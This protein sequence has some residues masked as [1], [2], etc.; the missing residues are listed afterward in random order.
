ME[1][2]VGLF[3]EEE[4]VLLLNEHKFKDLSNNAKYIIT[5]MFGHVNDEEMIHAQKIEGSFKP[6]FFVEVNGIRKNVSMKSG[7]NI[8]IHQELVKQF[9][10][11][12]KMKGISKETTD[13]I[14]L[15]HYGDMTTDGTGKERFPYRKI[16]Y[17][18][19]KRIKKANVELNANKEFVLVMIYR[20]VFIG[21][22]RDNIVAD[23][24]YH[25]DKEFGVVVSRKQVFKH[26]YNGKWDF[27]EN[28][29]IGPIILHP[30]ARYVGREIKNEKRRQTIEAHW[31]NF[32][33][34]LRYIAKRYNGIRR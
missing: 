20:L 18:L 33:S 24:I 12:L 1:K 23:Y 15:Y 21:T 4:M 16:S 13:T 29:H 10:Q 3:N 26:I 28:L 17:L 34:D 25:G 9:V 14:L 31:P 5:E 7:R 19:D 2:N 30:H 32:Y 22:H 11:F 6:D 27:L 8:I